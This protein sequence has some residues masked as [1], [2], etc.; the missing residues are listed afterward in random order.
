FLQ[1]LAPTESAAVADPR[2]TSAFGFVQDDWS[3]R[4]DLTLNLGVRYDI[5]QIANVRNY[6]APVDRNNLQPRVGA[7]WQPGAGGRFLVRGG[8]G[9]YTQ[10]QLLFYI[11]RVQL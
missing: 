10:Q 6:P 8:A 4:P 3:V 5:E 7:A 1:G 11:N 9:L 2:S